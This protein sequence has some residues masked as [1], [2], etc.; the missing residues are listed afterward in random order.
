MGVMPTVAEQLRCARDAQ[1]LTVYHVAEATKIK[2]EHVRALDEGNYNAF[3]ASVYIRGF[4]RTYAT[5]LKLDVPQIMSTLD[6]ELAQ[7]KEFCEPP[8]LAVESR[9]LLD[10]IMLQ[11]SRINWRVAIPLGALLLGFGLAVWGYRAW[12]IHQAKDP[13]AD[14]GPG[15]YESKQNQAG[16]T[17]P[18]PQAP[19]RK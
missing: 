12:R 3:A 18:L 16:E 15:I 14:L 13:L 19:T 1:K 4:V 11:L 9:G 7:T 5:L 6:S 2:T 8:S 17:L 10:L